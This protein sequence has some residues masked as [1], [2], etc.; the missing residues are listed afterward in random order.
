MGLEQF[1]ETRVGDGG[2]AD[3]QLAQVWQSGQMFQA[4][5]RNASA[6]EIQRFEFRL[7]RE[8]REPRVV[9]L[10]IRQVERSQVR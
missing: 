10:R 8:V 3:G 7:E 6:I 9:D 1:V 5:V 2:V 4:G